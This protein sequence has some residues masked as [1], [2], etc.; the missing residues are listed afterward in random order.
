MVLLAL[1]MLA[2]QAL[3]FQ[4]C[5]LSLPGQEKKEQASSASL[6]VELASARGRWAEA[7]NTVKKSYVGYRY[8]I[9]ETGSPIT[10]GGVPFTVQVPNVGSITMTSPVGT[11]PFLESD[12]AAIKDLTV[13][14]MFDIIQG[15]LDSITAEP[16]KCENKKGSVQATFDGQAGY[17]MSFSVTCK[18]T[19]GF[20]LVA[21][22][23]FCRSSMAA[24]DR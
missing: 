16:E 20:E 14:R 7:K 22:M 23:E 9:R 4:N 11:G 8:V 15:A 1:A 2:A 5:A 21:I 18:T 13:D 24:C 3:L 19:R 12:V 17:P 10:T 6:A